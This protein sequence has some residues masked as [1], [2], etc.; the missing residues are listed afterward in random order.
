MQTWRGRCIRIDVDGVTALDVLEQAHCRVPCV[1]LH[2][3]RIALACLHIVGRVLEDASLTVCALRWVLQEVLADRC[4]V[5]SAQALLLLKLLLSVREATALV[6]LEVFAGKTLEPELAQLGLDLLF[7]GVVD[8][9]TSG[10]IGPEGL[11]AH[12]LLVVHSRRV[13]IFIKTALVF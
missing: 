11:G 4:Q 5:L 6:L 2:H 12:Q 10:F 3:F 1:V 7:P 8:L 9:G 13:E